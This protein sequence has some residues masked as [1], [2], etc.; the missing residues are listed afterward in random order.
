MEAGHVTEAARLK[1]ERIR[2]RQRE[3]AGGTCSPK[4]A[5]PV[6]Y[7]TPPGRYHIL[8]FPEL[9]QTTSWKATFQQMSL[10]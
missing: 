9:R 5:L 3:E 6:S 4:H 2:A 7:L 1:E 8:S 10:L